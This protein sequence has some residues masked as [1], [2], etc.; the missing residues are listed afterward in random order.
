MR[1]QSCSTL[2]KPRRCTITPLRLLQASQRKRLCTRAVGLQPT[3]RTAVGANEEEK[4]YDGCLGLLLE[5]EIP[6]ELGL[7][8]DDA[9][10]ELGDDL[11]AVGFKGLVEF[12]EPLF[13]LLVDSGLG[14]VGGSL[15]LAPHSNAKCKTRKVNRNRGRW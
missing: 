15:V 6:V 14:R 9:I 5:L 8:V 1:K 4:A 3:K 10:E 13:G 2:Q 11:V 7:Y 12:A